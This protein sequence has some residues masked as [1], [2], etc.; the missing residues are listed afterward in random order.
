LAD[1]GAA[2]QGAGG[3]KTAYNGAVKSL[4]LA[5]LVVFGCGF[6]AAG[7]AAAA[8]PAVPVPAPVAPAAPEVN[9]SPGQVVVI[10]PMSTPF[11]VSGGVRRFHPVTGGGTMDV[12]LRGSMLAPPDKSGELLFDL[13][14]SALGHL[15]WGNRTLVTAALRVAP[16]FVGE[17][18]RNWYRA[19]RGRLFLVD[20][21]GKRLYLP[22]TSIV[23]RPASRDGWLALSGR[24]SADVPAP[25]G[26]VD[27]S[28]DPAHVTGLGVNVEAFNREGEVVA[29]PIELRDLKVTF[30]AP[31]TTRVL[32]S[33]PAIIAGEAARAVQM[34]ARLE[35]RCGLGPKE[36]AVGVNLAW[37]GA[38]APNGEELQLYGR[39]LDGGT[40]WWDKL[41][42]LGEPEVA[43][44]VR[45]D[46][47]A[48]RAAFGPGAVVRVWLLG[49]LRT[50]MTFDGKGD[51]V[52][53]TDRA[54][55]NMK[56]LLGLAA[57]EQVVLIPVLLDFGLADGVSQ[58]GPDGAWQVP[59]R[60]DL[61]VDARKRGKLVAALE[62]FV[63]SF[64]RDPAVLAWDVMNEPE[65]AA[66]VVTPAYFADIQSLVKEL[67][68][69]VHR[70]GDLAT[71]GHHDVPDPQ[72][73]FRGRVASDLGQAHYYPFVESKP[74]P[75]PFGVTMAATFGPL[76]AG[77]GEAQAR[78]GQIASQITTAARAGHRLFMLW[79]WRGHESTGDGF[80]V[81]PYADEIKRAIATLRATRK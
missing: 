62:D 14:K 56:V 72:K 40:P 22:N 55:A 30:E 41:W 34:N 81:Q 51:P 68:D 35:Q 48:I 44:S 4:R 73:Y 63:K 32:P 58:T 11:R 79:S 45:A 52:M 54:R 24:P 75:T 28:F 6:R 39:I 67:V 12:R 20:A 69:A 42:D 9:G 53:V 60:P 10:D 27:P 31:V 64:A 47:H 49:D 50:G 5:L 16:A 77:W 17:G 18:K 13:R 57:A 19:H 7:A 8:T 70:Q 36:M 43:Q 25:L 37:P 21:K 15:P 78:K 74:N 29:G 80:A 59:D 76:P 71:V 46:F 1:Q 66:A 23:D 38:K 65:N 3:G 33:D 26:F 61:I 2:R